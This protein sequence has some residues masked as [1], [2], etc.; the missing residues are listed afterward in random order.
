[1]SFSLEHFFI[2]VAISTQV[3]SAP[4]NFVELLWTILCLKLNDLKTQEKVIL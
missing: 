1:M 4:L 3:A 2:A